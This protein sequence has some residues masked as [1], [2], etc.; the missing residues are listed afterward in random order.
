MKAVS[1]RGPDAAAEAATR[2]RDLYWYGSPRFSG[3]RA[4]H[5][6]ALYAFARIADDAVDET[7]DAEEALRRLDHLEEE[8]DRAFGGSPSP[9][10]APL[11]EAVRAHAIP[12]KDLA[13]LLAGL[14]SDARRREIS[15]YKEFLDYCRLAA[16]PAGR[17][18]LRIFDAHGPENEALSDRICT[19]LALVNFW[20]DVGPDLDRG[21]IYL[22]REDRERFGVTEESLRARRPDAPF[23]ALL[24]FEVGRARALLEEGRP[25]ARHVPFPLAWRV[26]AFVRGGLGLLRRIE[27]VGFD[28]FARR[29]PI[30]RLW[31]ARVAAAGWVRA[32][33]GRAGR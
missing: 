14:R 9:S 33:L 2:S 23:R 21:R 6:A 24:A 22:P 7:P 27:A 28:V 30:A 4:R 8:L 25:L 15:T 26:E 11:A 19:G 12:R 1:E 17:M 18:A 16:N 5:L 32:C 3:S 10:F 20:R 13:E 31:K 29:P